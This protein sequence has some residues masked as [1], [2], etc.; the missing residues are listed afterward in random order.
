M[1]TKWF[2]WYEE[3]KLQSVALLHSGDEIPSLIALSHGENDYSAELIKQIAEEIPGK[4]YAYISCG[5]MDDNNSFETLRGYGKYKQMHLVNPQA[6]MAEESIR[7]LT[8]NDLEIIERFYVASYPDNW[9]EPS[10]LANGKYIGWFAENNLTGIAGTNIYSPEYGIASLGNIATA[11]TSRG[12]K[13]S[14]KLTSYLCQQLLP[15]TPH[16]GLGVH[17]DNTVAISLY[18]KLGFEIV[19]EYEYRLVK[20]I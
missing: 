20:R 5:A 18:E 13:I 1:D 11:I 17:H 6:T 16:I 7:N 8:I 10:M 15:E 19:G 2:G 14:S 12:K 9:F 3:N 4:F